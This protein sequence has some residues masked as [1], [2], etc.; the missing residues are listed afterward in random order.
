MFRVE[1][2]IGHNRL[3]DKERTLAR[4]EGRDEHD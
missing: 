1:M 3:K 4:R 2:E